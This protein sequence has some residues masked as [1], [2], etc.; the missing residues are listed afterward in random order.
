MNSSNLSK[1]D[2]SFL[3]WQA[4]PKMAQ[5]TKKETK[6]EHIVFFKEDNWSG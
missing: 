6:A 1:L 4:L 3:Y 5:G 2:W